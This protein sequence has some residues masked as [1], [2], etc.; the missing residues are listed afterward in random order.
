MEPIRPEN[1]K[2][3]LSD[4]AIEI[5]NNLIQE[6]WNGE[7]SSFSL[8]ELRLLFIEHSLSEDKYRLSNIIPLY[9]KYG[10]S[11]EVITKFDDYLYFRREKKK[12]H[13]WNV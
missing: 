7:Y 6:R 5:I 2:I 11:I 12:K 10:W 4:E 3:Q 13:W 1:I 9:K 8:N